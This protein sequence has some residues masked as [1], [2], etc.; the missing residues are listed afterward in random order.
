MVNEGTTNQNLGFVNNNDG[1]DLTT[2]QSKDEKLRE[3]FDIKYKC[4]VNLTRLPM[5]Y[6]DSKVKR[7]QFDRGKLGREKIKFNVTRRKSKG[8]DKNLNTNSSLQRLVSQHLE[9]KNRTFRSCSSRHTS[10][11]DN[12]NKSCDED[13]ELPQLL[14]VCPS[15]K[16]SKNSIP[17]AK[18]LIP[19]ESSHKET[20]G[21]SYSDI[22]YTVE[23]I[24][25]KRAKSKSPEYKVKWKGY[26]KEESTWEPAESLDC[27][28]LI[29]KFQTNF[30]VEKILDSRHSCIKRDIEWS[31]VE[32][33]V[34]WKGIEEKFNTWEP[35]EVLSC[36][37]MIKE[38]EDMPVR[39]YST[40]HNLPI[41]IRLK[42]IQIQKILDARVV[43]EKHEY[44]I[45]WKGI[46][47]KVT[48]WEKAE[49]LNCW[50]LIKD[51]Q[52]FWEVDKILDK[53]FDNGKKCNDISGIA[54]LVRWKLK[55]FDEGYCTWEPLEVLS[56]IDLI[57]KFEKN[58]K[59]EQN[60]LTLS[61]KTKGMNAGAKH[62]SQRAGR[63]RKNEE[64][65]VV[66]QIKDKRIAEDGSIEY[67]IKWQNLSDDFEHD[68]SKLMGITW[69]PLENL[70]CK[71]LIHKYENE[72]PFHRYKS[73][74]KNTSSIESKLSNQ[75]KT[76][77]AQ[78]LFRK[79][80][81]KTNDKDN[82]V[83]NGDK[84]KISDEYVVE[85]IIDRHVIN[86]ETI[87]YFVKWKGYS[88]D[89]NTWEPSNHLYCF[90]LIRM[91]LS[92]FSVN[93]ILKKRVVE[94][95]DEVNRT[96]I[97]Y[98]V[99]WKGYSEKH[100]T[101]EPL[102]VLECNDLIRKWERS[103]ITLEPSGKKTLLSKT[104]VSQVNAKS[105]KETTISIVSPCKISLS[106]ITN[107]YKKEYNHKR[108]SDTVNGKNSL[109]EIEKAKNQLKQCSNSEIIDQT[110]S[111]SEVKV[112]KFS[113][114]NN[115]NSKSNGR[116]VDTSETINK[117]S[118]KTVKWDDIDQ[119]ASSA[120]N[121]R[122]NSTQQL[123]KNQKLLDVACNIHDL[124]SSES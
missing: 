78:K 108:I 117:K 84:A 37:E 26:S 88:Y 19:D 71:E 85:T 80:T 122:N 92:R 18:S 56:C 12:D 28:H 107:P 109:T 62:K 64:E 9:T 103:C 114:T 106:E 47:T 31:Q 33:L 7:K 39:V 99:S 96:G 59:L 118:R 23:E 112:I 45:K 115:T 3:K 25:D 44:R 24:L 110:Q 63:K 119:P 97:E 14:P 95:D 61:S 86:A 68:H 43:G 123:R 15:V 77:K 29:K 55:S 27:F 13:I 34:K 90:D 104:N 74:A 73:K 83:L 82:D 48:T 69:E 72:N 111:F 94:V 2:I 16:H 81:L 20:D 35:F 52:R 98:L 116:N 124:K 76:K 79:P 42:K 22:E 67:L 60:D 101:W 102:E 5:R 70:N 51:Y 32:Y 65:V 6:D 40:N 1:N 87:E 4:I 10:K 91:Y 50:K 75:N 41:K 113:K 38:Y 105:K 93:S 121:F 17:I 36:P 54:Y 100:N 120:V 21:H 8:C 66:E 89:E 46:E 11:Y 30:E 57:Q 58:K 53:I 49:N